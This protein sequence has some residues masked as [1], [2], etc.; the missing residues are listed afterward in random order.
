MSCQGDLV[1]LKWVA[2][3]NPP[4]GKM[5]SDAGTTGCHCAGDAPNVPSPPALGD[6][7]SSTVLVQEAP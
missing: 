4:T 3:Q 1:Q 2:T 6:T 7:V 5:N